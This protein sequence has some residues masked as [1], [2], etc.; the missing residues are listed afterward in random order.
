M[1]IVCLKQAVLEMMQL[2]LFFVIH[3]LLNN[4]N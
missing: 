2:V 1:F 4:Y 3:D